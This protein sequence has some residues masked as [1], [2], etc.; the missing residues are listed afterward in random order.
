MGIVCASAA[1][2]R[3]SQPC[4]LQGTT[5]CKSWKRYLK[6]NCVNASFSLPY[7]VW[8]YGAKLCWLLNQYQIK[9]G[10]CF[11]IMDSELLTAAA[12]NDVTFQQSYCC[13]YAGQKMFI[14]IKNCN[15]KDKMSLV[16]R[17]FSCVPPDFE[18]LCTAEDSLHSIQYHP[19]HL[20]RKTQRQTSNFYC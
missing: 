11:T 5:A 18:A 9:T 10:I 2:E 15:L 8:Y 14:L 17:E 3:G 12:I 7:F 6:K 13:Q 4:S 20:A 19:D 16:D 1:Q